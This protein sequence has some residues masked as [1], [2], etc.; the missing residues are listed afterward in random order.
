MKARVK[1]ASVVVSALVMAFAVGPATASGNK[2]V[3]APGGPHPYFAPWEQAAADAQK[4][5]GIASV[6][7][8][9]PA[10]WKL[11]L[12]QELLES[13]ASQGVNGIGIF[14]G[15]PVGVN[16]TISEL[17]ANGIPVAALGGCTQDPTDAAF[18]F[19]TDPFK[20]TYTMTK[21]LIASIGGKGAIVHLTGLLIDTNTTLREQAVQKA[22]DE[23]NGAV[24]LLQTVADTDDPTQ[25][26]QKINALLAASKNQI[27]GIVAT[28]HITS[29]VIAKSL[30]AIGD[31]RIKLVAFDDDQAVLDDVKDGFAVATYVQ[32]PYGQAYI[33]AY[34]LD[35]LASGA[36]KM[37]ADA[38]WV[39]TPQTAHFIDSGV[40]EVKADKLG[41]YKDELKKLTADIQSK[42]KSTYMDCK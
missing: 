7:Y 35:L 42:F 9:V 34:A 38:P 11:E 27:D 37:K 26:D 39:K 33:G 10:E 19:A 8:K 29:A 28:A 23:T 16:S 36:C 17:K 24:K 30:R 3:V 18:C 32:N 21:A 31:R 22:V 1:G 4:D 25:G 12:Q 20:T 41:A 15:D 13:L 14:P 40:L 2:I 5:F 6:Q